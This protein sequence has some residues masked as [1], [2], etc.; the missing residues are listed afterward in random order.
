MKPVRAR[1][2]FIALVV[3]IF[4]SF[5][6][7]YSTRRGEKEN[8]SANDKIENQEEHKQTKVETLSAIKIPFPKIIHQT[9][10]QKDLPKKFQEAVETWKKKN[11]DFAYRFYDDADC[12]NFISQ[13]FPQFIETYDN[14]EK[15]VEKADMFRYLI[16]YEEGGVYADIDT[17]CHSPLSLFF[18]SSKM[19]DAELFV[20]REL[21]HNKALGLDVKDQ[22]LQWFFAAKPRQPTLLLIAEEIEKRAA[23]PHMMSLDRR[24]KRMTFDHQQ[25][26]TLWKT[27][28]FLF[29]D[30]IEK[31]PPEALFV[32]DFC[33][34]GG[35]QNIGK[36]GVLLEHDFTGSW[37]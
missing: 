28:P 7:Y 22:F 17:Y 26:S 12:R 30:F 34:F 23:N 1:F 29:S 16:I 14:L 8:S 15:P 2:V 4:F 33:V 21:Q 24:V 20:G 36:P 9:W 18:D 27:G 3:I 10:K 6:V 25:A 37:K 5:F 19:K 35:C 32:A 11:P 13:K 31:T